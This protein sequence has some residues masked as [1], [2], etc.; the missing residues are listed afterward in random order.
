MVFSKIEQAELE[1][2][3]ARKILPDRIIYCSRAMPI[4]NEPSVIC[5]FGA[6]KDG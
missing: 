1:H 3:S 6:A 5:D 4:T 2:S